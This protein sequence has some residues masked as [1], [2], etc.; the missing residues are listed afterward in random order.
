MTRKGPLA[1][2]YEALWQEGMKDWHGNMPERMVNDQ[3]EEQFWAQSVARKKK[4][5]NRSLCCTYFSGA[6]EKH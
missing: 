6:S 2:N 1:I 4:G 5:A 3:L